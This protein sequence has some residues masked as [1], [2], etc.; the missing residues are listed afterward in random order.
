MEINLFYGEPKHLQMG[1]ALFKGKMPYYPLPKPRAMPCSAELQ[2]IVP[3]VAAVLCPLTRARCL[4]SQSG[5]AVP[6]CLP[7]PHHHSLKMNVQRHGCV[8]NRPGD[9]PSLVESRSEIG[10]FIS[11]RSFSLRNRTRWE[12]GSMILMGPFQLG[13]NHRQNV[14]IESS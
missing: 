12:L 11:S 5:S 1:L 9:C 7:L 13:T 3:L 4:R 6:S 2:N 14:I 10:C 8:W